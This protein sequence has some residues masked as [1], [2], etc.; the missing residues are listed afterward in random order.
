MPRSAP[1]TGESKQGLPEMRGRMGFVGIAGV[2]CHWSGAWVQPSMLKRSKLTAPDFERLV[3]IPRQR[4][5]RALGYKTPIVVWREGTSGRLGDK[6]VDKIDNARALPT[7]PQR[8]Q[9]HQPF[10]TVG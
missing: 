10:A 1:E 3:R 9:E 8:H 7:C 2:L 5:H 4:P 6:A